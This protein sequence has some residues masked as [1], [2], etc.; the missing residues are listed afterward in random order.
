QP[1]PVP[2]EPPRLGVR[3]AAVGGFLLVAAVPVHASQARVRFTRDISGP[4][5]FAPQ[6]CGLGTV[7]QGGEYEPDVALNPADRRNLIAIWSQDNQTS[8]VI[9]TSHDRGRH[10]TTVPLPGV[11][12]CTGGTAFFAFDARVSIG[13]DGIAYASS[14]TSGVV[15]SGIFY[16]L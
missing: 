6:G 7:D 8:N 14:L 12:R 10:W 3:L 15:G 1:I 16:T 11:S 5:P 2:M 9:A 4:S 13:S